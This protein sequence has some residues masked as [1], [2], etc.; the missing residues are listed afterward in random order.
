MARNGITPA[1]HTAARD[2]RTELQHMENRE[3][4]RKFTTQTKNDKDNTKTTTEGSSDK[5]GDGPNKPRTGDARS[6]SE[7]GATG[8]LQRICSPSHRSTSNK[9]TA[10]EVRQASPKSHKNQYNKKNE[11]HPPRETMI[12][13][14][15]K[16]VF[17]ERGIGAGECLAKSTNVYKTRRD[18]KHETEPRKNTVEN[19][20]SRLKKPETHRRWTTQEKK[21]KRYRTEVIQMSRWTMLIATY[22]AAHT[23]NTKMTQGPETE[24][25][26]PQIR[27]AATPNLNQNKLAQAPPPR[28]PHNADTG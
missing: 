8:T 18:G 22:I 20:Q 12:N 11:E 6:N 5:C 13:K 7:R 25:T 2:N 10:S 16:D 26:M 14:T 3:P 21:P 9:T 24:G 1:G 27:T 19:T 28:G 17:P 15:T 4:G 23:S